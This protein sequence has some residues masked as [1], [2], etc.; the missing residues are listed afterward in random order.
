MRSR[1]QHAAIPLMV[2]ACFVFFCFWAK[3]E[4]IGTYLN[5]FREQVSRITICFSF[6][7]LLVHLT[8]RIISIFAISISILYLILCYINLLLESLFLKRNYYCERKENYFFLYATSAGL[9]CARVSSMDDIH[10]T[11]C[12]YNC[13]IYTISNVF[14]LATI[15]ITLT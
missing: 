7:L 9:L 12:V 11:T 8:T 15:F 1:F 4:G 2:S 10:M 5:L 13:R 3:A 14:N 6:L